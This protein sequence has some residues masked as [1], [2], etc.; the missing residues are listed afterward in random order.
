MKN[1]WITIF[2]LLVF[3]KLDEIK[4]SIMKAL[5]ICSIS[6]LL[7]SGS[8]AQKKIAEDPIYGESSNEIQTS[9]PTTHNFLIENNKLIWQKVF[10]TKLD[11]ESLVSQ[12]KIAGVIEN[13]EVSESRITGDLRRLNIDYRGAGFKSANVSMIALGCDLLG[14]VV[15]DFKEYKYRITIKNIKYIWNQS[16]PIAKI[17]QLTEMDEMAIRKGEF[18]KSFFN[19]NQASVIDYSFINAFS[20]STEKAKDN[21]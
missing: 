15:V 5:I 14:Y 8:F 16:T 4:K 2:L 17:D 9:E 1:I 12:L 10:D 21:W 11:F 18:K 13:I 6:V 3:L 7:Y 20:F 19:V